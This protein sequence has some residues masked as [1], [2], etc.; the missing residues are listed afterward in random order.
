[1]RNSVK[2]I[3]RAVQRIDNP[4]MITRLVAHDSFLAVK[5]VLG[6]FS[7]Q[8]F[9][10]QL[11][12]LDIDRELDVVRQQGADVLR[13]IKIFAKQL[14]GLTRRFLSCIE[15]MLHTEIEKLSCFA[16]LSSQLLNVSTAQRIKK[17]GGK[18]NVSS[19]VEVWGCDFEMKFP[20]SL[21]KRRSL[22]P[23]SFLR[24]PFCCFPFFLSHRLYSPLSIRF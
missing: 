18:I 9:G 17:P 13:A 15:I 23:F 3:H 12:G 19:R 16:A 24:F 10:D 1:M 8:R 4:L 20:K 6:K 7:Q 22:M 14:A 21:I 11:L 5:C 2:I